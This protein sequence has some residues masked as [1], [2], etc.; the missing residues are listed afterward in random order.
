[1]SLSPQHFAAQLVLCFVSVFLQIGRPPA[2]STLCCIR[3][4]FAMAGRAI[5]DIDRRVEHIAI[6]VNMGS[7]ETEVIAEQYKELLRS[8]SMIRG[9]DLAG[10]PASAATWCKRRCFLAHSFQHSVGVL[11]LLL[12]PPVWISPQAG[13]CNPTYQSNIAFCSTTGTDCSNLGRSQ[14]NQLIR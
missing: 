10:S 14:R 4:V 13:K 2:V 9:V 8:F 1:M 12:L 5:I 11:E 6:Q 7:D 3:S